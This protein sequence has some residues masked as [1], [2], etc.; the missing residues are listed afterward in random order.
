MLERVSALVLNAVFPP[1]CPVC[2]KLV[3]TK[4]QWCCDCVE[5][6]LCLRQI[7]LPQTQFRHLK[8]CVVLCLYRHGVKAVLHR[9]KFQHNLSGVPQLSWLL[10]QKAASFPLSGFDFVAPVPLHKERL[11]ERGFNQ[12]EALFRGWVQENGWVWQDVLMRCRKTMPQYQLQKKQRWENV[13]DAFILQDFRTVAGKKILLVDDIFTT[14][15][16]M[17]ACARALRAA[18]AREVA[19]FALAAD[20][21]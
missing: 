16:T 6:V 10:Q 4:G 17:E 21:K 19:G 11:E 20:T 1:A 5:K 13:R 7:Y 15:A 3:D 9:I 14:G 18:G 8:S 12:T 2:N